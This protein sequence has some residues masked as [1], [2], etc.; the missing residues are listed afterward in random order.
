MVLVNEG[1]RVLDEL[2]RRAAVVQVV[3]E[4]D[5]APVDPTVGVEGVEVGDHARG[6]PVEITSQLPGLR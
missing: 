6:E 1:V 4:Y 3:G 2:G 5:T